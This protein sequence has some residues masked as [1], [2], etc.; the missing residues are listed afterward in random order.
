MYYDQ[1]ISLIFYVKDGSHVGLRHP[2]CVYITTQRLQYKRCVHLRNNF[3][4]SITLI[5]VSQAGT[6]VLQYDFENMFIVYL[7]S[8]GKYK[9]PF[10]W[11]S[12]GI[13]W[14]EVDILYL[15]IQTSFC[16]P[17]FSW[18]LKTQDIYQRLSRYPTRD[19]WILNE[20]YF[21]IRGYEGTSMKLILHFLHVSL[22]LGKFYLS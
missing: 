4:C 1:N 19:N 11:F 10:R 5:G 6:R 9:F 7:R 13:V 18:P 21:Y 16:P 17:V 22:K 2:S 15:S 3:P 14:T 8:F 12:T 20:I